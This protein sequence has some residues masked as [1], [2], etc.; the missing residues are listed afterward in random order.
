MN[1][2]A[3]QT[4][5]RA[6]LQAHPGLSGVPVV[7]DDGTGE[8]NRERATALKSQGL[9]LLVWRVESGGIISASRT[10]AVVQRLLVFVFVEESL[11]VCRAPG[12]LNLAVETATQ[13]VM[14]A[15]SGARVGPDRFT[16]DEPPFD[17]LGRVN[18]VNRVLVN[19]TAELT[20]VPLP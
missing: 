13:R 11:A 12:G 19:A 15:L 14:E 8:A 9:C 5:V 3:V 20:T 2:D 18:G 10:G 6:R 16:L 4:S 17:N 1:L 7:L